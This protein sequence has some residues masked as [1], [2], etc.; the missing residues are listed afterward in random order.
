MLTIHFVYFSIIATALGNFDTTACIAFTYELVIAGFASERLVLY[1][2]VSE[3]FR[4]RSIQKK[5]AFI[6]ALSL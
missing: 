6:V 1:L 2:H 4:L 3:V 5:S